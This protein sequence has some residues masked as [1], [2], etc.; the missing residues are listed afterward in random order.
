MRIKCAWVSSSSVANPSDCSSRRNFAGRVVY[1]AGLD[2]RKIRL[3]NPRPSGQFIQRQ[4][5]P[6]ALPANF[7]SESVHDCQPIKNVAKIGDPNAIYPLHS[8]TIYLSVSASKSKKNIVQN[9]NSRF[10]EE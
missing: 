4:P 6:A 7:C 5:K 3:G 9:P 1:A 8:P 2:E 10:G